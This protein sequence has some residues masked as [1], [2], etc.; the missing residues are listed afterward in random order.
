MNKIKIGCPMNKYLIG[1]GIVQS[2]Q[3]KDKAM[4]RRHS[5]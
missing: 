3:A 2:I 1:T 4:V 5:I